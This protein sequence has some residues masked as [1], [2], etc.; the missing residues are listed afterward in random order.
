MMEGE[1]PGGRRDL[2]TVP[3]AGAALPGDGAVAPSSGEVT[4]FACVGWRSYSGK[5][6]RSEG[7][8]ES[9][10]LLNTETGIANGERCW[11]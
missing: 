3:L 9:G 1:N 6:A 4:I 2:E 8:M 7:R 11:K 10:I 5:R